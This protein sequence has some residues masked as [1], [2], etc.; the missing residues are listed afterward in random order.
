MALPSALT[1]STQ[2]DLRLFAAED[3]NISDITDYVAEG[4]VTAD[5]KG[6]LKI[7]APNGIVFYD[8]WDG[9]TPDIDQS[10]SQAAGAI[11]IYKNAAYVILN[12]IYRIYYRA[13]DGVDT[14]EK[15][16]DLDFT[17]EQPTPNLVLTLDG[18][19]STGKSEDLTDYT[20][21]TILSRLHTF[22]YPTGSGEPNVPV[23]GQV[24]NIDPL[25]AGENS[26]TLSTEIEFT[27]VSGIHVLDTITDD[28]Q[29]FAYNINNYN[30]RQLA[31]DFT[32]E[33]VGHLGENISAA[34]IQRAD[35]NVMSAYLSL[36]ELALLEKNTLKSYEYG[37]EILDIITKNGITPI[38]EII[39]EFTFPGG[40][41]VSPLTTKGDIYTYTT[42]DARFG[43]GLDGQVL[44]AN[45]AYSTGLEWVDFPVSGVTDHGA[46]T[47]LG[48]DDHSIYAL[49]SGRN[50][51]ELKIDSIQEFNSGVGVYVGTVNI[52]NTVDLPVG[53][54]LNFGSGAYIFELPI[55]H[56]LQFNVDG[57]VMD[58]SP[59]QMNYY[60]IANFRQNL[61]VNV[62][63]TWNSVDGTYVEGVQNLDGD[64]YAGLGTFD[65]IKLNTT[66]TIATPVAGDIWWNEDFY[67]ANI[68]TGL[69]AD[70][71][72]GQETYIIFYNDTG[73]IIPNGAVLRPKAATL[74]GSEI[75]PTI[76]LASAETFSGAEGTLMVATIEVAIGE[77][78]VATRFGRVKDVD[79][80]LFSPGDDL[81]LSTTPGELTNVRPNFPNYDI[82]IGGAFNSSVTGEIIVS[83]TRDIFHTTKNFW[84]GTFRE[85][86]DFLITSSVGVVTGTLTPAG[87]NTDM[88]C[89][90]SDGLHLLDTS[91]SATVQLVPGTDTAPVFNYVYVPISTKVLTV[92]TSDWPSEEHIKVA[93]VVL[94]SA[95]ATE[96]FGAL[97]NQN[98]NDHI[99]GTDG[100]G[101][102]S[103]MT[104]RI[105]QESSKWYSGVLGS[106]T[107]TGAAPEDIWVAA[108]GGKVYQMHKQDFPAI[109][110]QT[111]GDV[112]VVNHSTTPYTAIQNLNTQ[113]LDAN[114]A[115]L[116]DGSFSFVLWGVANKSGEASH[117]MLNLPTDKYAF[118]FPDSAVQ[119][120]S[121]YDVY[122]IPAQFNGVGFLIARFTM[123]YKNN[124]WVLY[125]TEDLRGRVPNIS[126]GGGGGGGVGATTYLA[127]T[128]TDS[129]YAGSENLPVSV[130]SAGTALEF[131][132]SI[133]VTTITEAVTS[134]GIT[135]V[136]QVY[137]SVLENS[138]SSYIMYYDTGTGKVSYSDALISSGSSLNMVAN[139]TTDI[140][141]GDKTTESA[142]KLE[143]TI[144]RGSVVSKG[145][146][147]ILNIDNSSDP[148]VSF[149]SF[150]NG[151]I[152]LTFDARIVSDDIILE[153]TLDNS[154]TNTADLYYT[155]IKVKGI[156]DSASPAPPAAPTNL[157]GVSYGV[158]T[159]LVWDANSE[160]T[161]VG[162]NLYRSTISGSGY[163]KVN[164]VIIPDGT[165]E[166][167]DTTVEGNISYYYVL[168]AVTDSPQES[169]YSTEEFINRWDSLVGFGADSRFAYADIGTDPIVVYVDTTSSATSN[170]DSTHG[171]FSWAVGL[172]VPRV[173]LFLTS[174]TIDY[175]GVRTTLNFGGGYCRIVGQSAPS[176]GIEVLGVNT[177][178]AGYSDL[179]L[180]HYTSALGDVGYE[181]DVMTCH[182][183]NVVLD[184]M[185]ARWGT[186]ENVSGHPSDT[187][188]YMHTYSRCMI[189]EPLMNHSYKTKDAFG[190][191]YLSLSWSAQ[192]TYAYNIMAF[193]TERFPNITYPTSAPH[194]KFALIN[195][196][197]IGGWE[198]TGAD[199]GTAGF[200]S[201]IV[202]V[203]N[204]SRRMNNDYT[205]GYQDYGIMVRPYATAAMSLYV[206]DIGCKRKDDGFS[207][208]ECVRDASTSWAITDLAETPPFSIDEYNIMESS[209]VKAAL[210]ARSGSM[211]MDEHSIR[212]RNDINNFN[213]RPFSLEGNDN[214]SSLVSGILN[215]PLDLPAR[216]VDWNNYDGGFPSFTGNEIAF[217]GNVISETESGLDFRQFSVGHYIVITGSTS[218]NV[219]RTITATSYDSATGNS[220]ITVDGA[221]FTAEGEGATVTIVA[222]FDWATTNQSFTINATSGGVNTGN[223]VV[224]L[225]ADCVN[226][227]AAL[228]HVNA[229][230][231][232]AGVDGEVEAYNPGSDS[233]YICLQ[234]LSTGE[235]EEIIISSSTATAIGLINATYTGEETGGHI[236]RAEN[237][238][239][240]TPPASPHAVWGSGVITN[241]EK[242][243]FDTFSVEPVEVP[244][245]SN[246]NIVINGGGDDTTDWVD[247]DVN[248]LADSWQAGGTGTYT[249]SIVTGNGFIGNAQRL[250][251]TD[252][253][254]SYAYLAHTMNGLTIGEEY[255]LSFKGRG[256]TNI[257]MYMD[258]TLSVATCLA[259]SGTPNSASGDF[260]AT[261]TTH[262]LRFYFTPTAPP[263]TN[264]WYEIDEVNFKIK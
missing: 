202:F 235:N 213:Y 261:A 192:T 57:L 177:S 92:S 6:Y 250:V 75:I 21:L 84:N 128:D 78:G 121:N 50:G 159:Y 22:I 260:T 155:K 150:G 160:P 169:P 42:Q 13:T 45:S 258:G 139:A 124:A 67:T 62:I 208:A 26:N 55:P 115:A 232:V 129:A 105:R 140:T 240:L 8:N 175:R 233:T 184:R 223:V 238:H 95:T 123:T 163:V 244:G 148:L 263:A 242:W 145:V 47:G 86:I 59:S 5:V 31:E 247:T 65:S 143:Y 186:D 98:W 165:E 198:R 135:L 4:V 64:I 257:R 153:V 33:F 228:A 231:V 83:V 72:V 61:K 63:D 161:L 10:V 137:M 262:L 79:T 157:T 109:D 88:T 218:N 120:A 264:D 122:D 44:I 53:G 173:I 193:G 181:G 85:S 126:A 12:G 214:H 229:R 183:D 207:D 154:T 48:D 125:S 110:T 52:S 90:F 54:R 249:H 32:E 136:N 142:I 219:T 203:G 166:Y 210:L 225:N 25:W 130:N 116:N 256:S 195:N 168:T 19:A 170:S 221:A 17:Y 66:H 107:L 34:D 119:D 191:P 3:I 73:S 94:Q 24:I 190:H 194:S 174:G 134:S 16:F 102:L 117:L 106:M 164:T 243:I 255:T 151:T 251:Y 200:E 149:H 212:N 113:V 11:P 58:I 205:S 99:Q 187:T 1:I 87:T 49:L 68:S 156:V 222:G 197:T 43:I 20:G 252:V 241:L 220:T 97:R 80:S 18:Y 71:Q 182:G 133:Y 172:S 237:T 215:S 185:D 217:S 196:Y 89:I 69:G 27:E 9:V 227:A 2:F 15:T 104:E 199:V 246:P 239:V 70:L 56:I 206:N 46:L 93:S 40:G 176:P 171:S 7:Q 234:T 138:S 259:T 36:Y 112:H 248:G 111:T 144:Q 188:S 103:H 132:D 29:D 39:P 216:A 76:E 211:F 37:V 82:S 146:V 179:L 23:A 204:D 201:D 224:T 178:T 152:G 38:V 74:V 77:I 114:G 180:Q 41:G 96:T 253:P 28:N 236:A 226:F 158:Q 91:P 108:T 189:Y 254:G 245:V 35:V 101:H 100:Q 14:W 118:A 230:L 167:I 209:A 127:L 30:V 147:E 162:Y 81:F 141:V 60:Q 131:R 51:D